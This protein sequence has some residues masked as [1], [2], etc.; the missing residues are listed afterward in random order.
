MDR[1]R[2]AKLRRLLILYNPA[3]GQRARRRLDAWLG[4]LRDL[5]VAARVAETAGPGHAEDLARAADAAEFDAVVAAGGDG[6]ANEALNGLAASSLPLAL[7]PL[8][9]A[10]VLAHEL[11]LPRRLDALARIAAFAPARAVRPAEAIAPNAS[12]G[13]RFLLMAGIGFD[14]AVVA[15]LNER[16][17]RCLGK[18]AY[19]ASILGR[20]GDYRP[21]VFPVRIDGVAA[22]PASLV[23]ARAHFYGGRFVLAP[24]ARLDLPLLEIV[25]FERPGRAAA[26]AYLAAL[27]LGSLPR[28]R[29]VR[30]VSAQNVEVLGP[31]GL[32]VQIDGDVRARLPVA[33]RLAPTAQAIIAPPA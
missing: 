23:A 11:G 8:G 31:A 22:E 13:R 28:R 30:I 19:V 32:P 3:A 2:S 21:C 24:K 25:L 33:L 27:A 20:L 29:D 17:K 16:L 5:G 14:A 4:H 26:L 9:T 1:D 10:N 12:A 18:A 6:T 15:G 7:L